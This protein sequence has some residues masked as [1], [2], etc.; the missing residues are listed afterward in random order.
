MAESTLAGRYQPPEQRPSYQLD[1]R[2]DALLQ[3]RIA[4]HRE[5]L[6]QRNARHLSSFRPESSRP[7]RDEL[8]DAEVG[9]EGLWGEE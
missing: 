2:L 9:L 4:D 5:F 8:R 3:H 6:A 1:G 7:S